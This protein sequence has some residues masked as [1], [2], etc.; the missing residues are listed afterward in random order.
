MTRHHAS[1]RNAYPFP[2]PS[3]PTQSVVHNP[4][5][6]PESVPTETLLP[7][8]LQDRLAPFQVPK[9]VEF[10]I[11][12]EPK[13]SIWGA[14]FLQAAVP[15]K[16][17]VFCLFTFQAVSYLHNPQ[18]PHASGLRMVPKGEWGSASPLEAA[19]PSTSITALK[20]P[21]G[22]NF[23]SSMPGQRM[24]QDHTEPSKLIAASWQLSPGRTPFTKAS[25]GPNSDQDG[26]RHPCPRPAMESTSQVPSPTA[27][28]RGAGQGRGTGR[29]TRF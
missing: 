10:Y 4:R 17:L 7:R 23:P 16:P 19:A 18:H 14:D 21:A 26:A 25:T 1:S 8:D 6:D 27:P 9:S 24:L 29:G 5:P 2:D 11:K 20:R 28:H 15:G 3:F 13:L 12:T 22:E